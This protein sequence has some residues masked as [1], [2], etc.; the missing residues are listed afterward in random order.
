MTTLIEAND[1][2][3]PLLTLEIM[4]V[5]KDVY[6]PDHIYVT[7]AHYA[8]GALSLTM[9][10]FVPECYRIPPTHLTRIQIVTYYGQASYLLGA[11]MA[12]ANVLG[13]L[14]FEDYQCR[15]QH[16]RATFRKLH[17]EFNRFIEPQLSL[18]MTVRCATRSDGSLLVRQAHDIIYAP[19]SFEINNS[20]CVGE[21]EAIILP[22][23]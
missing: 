17:L 15:V 11:F 22:I 12:K 20:A 19:L 4:S 10:W 1:Q 14:S 16:D 7:N 6:N 23:L 13:T 9:K 3:S 21:S 5:L 18:S 8:S 2:Q